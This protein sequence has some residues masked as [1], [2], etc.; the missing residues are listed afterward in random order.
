MATALAGAAT[1]GGCTMSKA[2]RDLDLRK[3]EIFYWV[4]ELRSFSL[5]AEHFSLRQPTVT[6]HVQSLEHQLD[7]KLF[8]RSGGRFDLTSTGWMLYEQAGAVLKLKHRALAALDRIQ[9]KVEGELRIGGSNVPGEYILPGVLG[10][11]VA[12]FPDVRPVLR[13][14]DSAAIVSAIL[15]GTLELGFTGFRTRDERLRYRKTWQDEMIV[16]VPANHRWAGLKQV[17]LQDLGKER[18]IAREG[19]SGTLRSFLQSVAKRGHDP[20]RLLNVGMELGS[21]AAVK[22]ALMEGFGF[23]V[24]SRAAIRREVQQGL[25]KEVR[26]KGVDLVRPFYQVTYRERPLA[27]VSRAFVQFLNRAPRSRLWEPV[28][29]S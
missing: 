19:G 3:L 22:E 24:L 17:A 28:S 12:Q 25:I 23:S 8:R 20:E 6:A 1:H 2:S 15:D 13:I 5:A 21:T 11:F 26:V 4:A 29:H 10:S 27:P 14:G 18:F 16:A 9:G 7:C